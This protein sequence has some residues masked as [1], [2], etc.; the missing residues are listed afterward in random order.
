E[1]I[2]GIWL[3]GAGKDMGVP[4]PSQIADKL[5]GRWFSHFGRFRAAFWKV[6]GEDPNLVK[7]FKSGNLGNI[8]NGKVPSPKEREQVGRRVKY[9]L[10]HLK[11][12]S[13]NG[14][15][16]HIENIR[17]LTPKRHI[18]IHKGAE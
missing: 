14:A 11:P 1:R 4:I 2:T 10:H 15:V 16:Y 5:R 13:K 3:A 6:V 7:Y 12:I 8:K 9:E 18:D 17:V